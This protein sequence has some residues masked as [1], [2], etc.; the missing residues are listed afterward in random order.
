MPTGHLTI[1]ADSSN[2]DLA[3][4]LRRRMTGPAG[5]GGRADVSISS[6]APE[7]TARHA[8]IT[9]PID[10]E[11]DRWDAAVAPQ[12]LAAALWVPPGRDAEEVVVGWLALRL[13]MPAGPLSDLTDGNGRALRWSVCAATML[14][15]PSGPEPTV[16]EEHVRS[17]L[18][19]QQQVRALASAVDHLGGDTAEAVVDGAQRFREAL[20]TLQ[21]LAVLPAA[22]PS[23]EF[24]D[25]LADLLGHVQRR[26]MARWR[27]G[28][29]RQASR[30][31]LVAAG[32]DLAGQRLREVIDALV[33][34]RSEQEAAQNEQEL[35]F[36]RAE[37]LKETV[38]DLRLPV[39]VDFGRVPRT[40]SNGTPDPRRYV[41]IS[42]EDAD[43]LAD[44]P[45][46]RVRAHEWIAQGTA[47]CLVVQAGFSLPALLG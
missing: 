20:V 14:T 8:V 24:D 10:D 7:A 21:E 17:W 15:L 44:V 1:A 22:R 29:A 41:L 31:A 3:E 39:S 26:G 38:S 27:G 11:V 36:R 42:E 28:R 33:T 12:S 23:T 18:D 45:G 9:G 25:A 46:A 30:E 40:W 4:K 2:A 47:L 16:D 19:E 6:S 13:G 43:A 5:H 37:L 32:R 35:R 34:A